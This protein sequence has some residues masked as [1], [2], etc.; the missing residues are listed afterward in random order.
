MNRIGEDLDDKFGHDSM[1]EKWNANIGVEAG[2][3]REIIERRFFSDIQ[4]DVWAV[5]LFKDDLPLQEIYLCFVPIEQRENARILDVG[6]GPVT[7]L[8]KVYHGKRVDL[9]AVD[10]LADRYNEMLD[11]NAWNPPVRTQQ[12][13][14]EQLVE[15]FG[16]EQFD[17]VNCRNALDHSYNPVTAIQQMLAVLKEN[18]ALLIE[19]AVNEGKRTSYQGLHSWDINESDGSLTIAASDG[20]PHRLDRSYF[21]GKVELIRH[22]DP[23]P[24]WL[25]VWFYKHSHRSYLLNKYREASLLEKSGELDASLTAFERLETELGKDVQ[26]IR[27]GVLYHQGIICH[28]MGRQRDAIARLTQC[29][30][31][32]PEHRK[33]AQFLRE[34]KSKG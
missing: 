13:H 5:D 28:L 29:L 20:V 15:K 18:R 9:T 10:A 1:K 14:A 26:D 4:R 32:Q 12:C 25:R 30:H 3:W 34:W 23:Q 8:G 24:G 31:L 16:L 33:A 17:V 7:I 11:E 27:S 6:S 22:E 19:S 21:G 2:H